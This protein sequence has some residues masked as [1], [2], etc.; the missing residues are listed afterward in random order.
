MGQMLAD[1]IDAVAACALFNARNDTNAD[2]VARHIIGRAKELMDAPM[3]T[4]P[5]EI[6]AHN[7]ALILYQIIITF[8]DDVS[9]PRFFHLH[10]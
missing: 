7:Q 10:F 2:F 1:C 4:L 5:M 8:S 9:F 6:L 3:P